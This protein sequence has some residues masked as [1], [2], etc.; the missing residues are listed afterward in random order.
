MKRGWVLLYFF[1][2]SRGTL[3]K[4]ARVENICIVTCRGALLA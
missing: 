2:G 3:Q 1:C 4:R